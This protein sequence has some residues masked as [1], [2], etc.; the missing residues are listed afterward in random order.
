MTGIDYFPVILSGEDQ[1]ALLDDHQAAS[2]F[3]ALYAFSRAYAR[4]EEPAIEIEDP[5][6]KIVFIGMVGA[7][8]DRYDEYRRK[9]EI[10]RIN[11]LGHGAPIG[12]Q[13]ARKYT[14]E[15]VEEARERLRNGDMSAARILASAAARR[16]KEQENGP[17]TTE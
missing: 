5:V 17:L 3:R 7:I 2:L 4:G 6:V 9:C 11:A 10:N 1:V 16:C 14:E 12:N 15:E 8:R 13:N